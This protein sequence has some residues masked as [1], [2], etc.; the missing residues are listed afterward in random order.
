MRNLEL[1]QQVRVWA[2]GL[3]RLGAAGLAQCGPGWVPLL[4]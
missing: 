3:A 1:L 2:S 4:L